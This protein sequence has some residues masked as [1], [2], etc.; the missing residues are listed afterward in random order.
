[1][2]SGWFD[3]LKQYHLGAITNKAVIFHWRSARSKIEIMN[4]IFTSA[5]GAGIKYQA[6][7]LF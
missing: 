1:M 4:S 5:C 3:K 2:L 6:V 7:N